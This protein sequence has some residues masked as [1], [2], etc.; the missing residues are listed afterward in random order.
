M[1]ANEWVVSKTFLYSGADLDLG[2]GMVI[3][4]PTAGDIAKL[5]NGFMTDWVYWSYV[6]TILSDPYDHM[7]FLDDLGLDYETQTPFDVFVLRWEHTDDHFIMQMALSFFLGEREFDVTTTADGVKVIYD[8][9][10]TAYAFTGDIFDVLHSFVEKM[11][12]VERTDKINP[13][14]PAAKRI[15]IEDMREEQK[16]KARKA[17]QR[18]EKS[19]SFDLIG[20][21]I[22]KVVFGPGCV[23]PL[24]AMDLHVY[25]IM[26]GAISSG[27]KQRVDAMLNGVYTGM[28]KADK[29][30]PEDFSWT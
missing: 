30:P 7:V 14:D 13:G 10:D 11:N 4:H 28:L 25:H 6:W 27:K 20:D 8:K 2:N 12:C 3:R 19:E 26:Q 22:T 21:G 18:T 29:M 15:L 23:S 5:N 17:S 1:G 9:N 16:R 24:Q